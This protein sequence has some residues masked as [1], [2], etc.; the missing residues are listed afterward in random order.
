MPEMFLLYC[1]GTTI[2]N[3]ETLYLLD[4]NKNIVYCTGNNI[5]SSDFDKIKDNFNNN[6]DLGYQN[7]KFTKIPNNNCKVKETVDLDITKNPEEFL[8]SEAIINGEILNKYYLSDI[9]LNIFEKTILFKQFFEKNDLQFYNKLN[10]NEKKKF[11]I[12]LLF[13]HFENY[14]PIRNKLHSA[15]QIKKQ[16]TNFNEKDFLQQYYKDNNKEIQDFI[17]ILT[18]FKDVFIIVV[19]KKLEEKIKQ[20][21]EEI[22]GMG[23]FIFYV[24]FVILFFGTIFVLIYNHIYH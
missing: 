2:Q 7:N 22:G 20:K 17:N 15:I 4:D 6:K 11:A 10:N 14:E 8:A 18:E 24:L 5:I 21:I 13:Y 19:E 16:D 3:G 9:S 1:I 12:T 23:A